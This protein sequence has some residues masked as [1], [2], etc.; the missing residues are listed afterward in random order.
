MKSVFTIVLSI[1]IFG[2]NAQIPKDS[3]FFYAPFNGDYND[4]VGNANGNASGTYFTQD[5]H[6]LDSNAL[7]LDGN[8]DLVDYGMKIK[9]RDIDDFSS[10]VWVQPS[11]VNYSQPN[12]PK[13]GR[14][15]ICG[16]AAGG[17]GFR[18]FQYKNEL[19]F[20]VASKV[21]ID[22]CY[23]TLSAQEQGHW[24]HLVGTSN[25][26]KL[27]IYVNG[28]HVSTVTAQGTNR[29]IGQYNFEVGRG[30]LNDNVY[31]EGK[32]DELRVYN[33]VLTNKEI[34]NLYEAEK[35]LKTVCKET[36]YDTVST[37]VY[38]F[39]TITVEKTV[40]DTTTTI[41]YEYDTVTVEDT[42]NI[43]FSTG[44]ANYALHEL[45]LYP[46]PTGSVL[47]IQVGDYSKVNTFNFS[48][49]NT[50]GQVVWSSLANANSFQLN[51]ADLKG[52]G[53]FYFNIY[54]NQANLVERKAIVVY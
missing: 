44:N 22:Y 16:D 47:N 42:L 50:L 30:T 18:F 40:Y 27:G 3:L 6:S 29:T 52:T 14:Y 39:D 2:A 31:W 32:V 19:H 12:G 35:F 36:V 34:K 1:F 37:Q 4:Y 41:V 28:N 49:T 11:A 51:V 54:D 23:Y 24:V 20:T 5:R 26:G 46:N 53:L 38:V 48:I 10:S 21:G 17:A 9:L 33:K 43:F 13:S 45:K 25:N 8:N 7:Y 15:T